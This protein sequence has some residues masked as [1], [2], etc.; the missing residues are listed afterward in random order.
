MVIMYACVINCKHIIPNSTAN[1]E[2]QQCSARSYVVLYSPAGLKLVWCKL[3]LVQLEIYI[4]S[5]RKIKGKSSKRIFTAA[6]LLR[7]SLR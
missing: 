3:L 5:Y 7:K 1:R 2:G 6:F 4:I